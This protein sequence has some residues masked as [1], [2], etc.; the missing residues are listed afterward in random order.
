MKTLET[1][2]AER[3]AIAERVAAW[4]RD[5]LAATTWDD[6]LKYLVPIDEMAEAVRL[7]Q[8]CATAASPDQLSLLPA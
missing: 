2:L 3:D 1:L 6:S 5:W 7:R 8:D 4:Q